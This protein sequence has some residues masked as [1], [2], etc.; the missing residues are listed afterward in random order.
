M[1]SN[2]I[3]S[4]TLATL[5][6]VTLTVSCSENETVITKAVKAESS[7]SKS[8]LISLGVY[9]SPTCGCCKKWIE[10]IEDNGFQSETHSIRDVSIIKKKKGIE[11]RYRSCHTAV[12]NEGYVF[13]GHVP[14]KYIQQFLT[15]KHDDN[16]IGLSVPSMPVGSPG[17]R[18][19]INLVPIECY[20]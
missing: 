3:I 12:S 15:E 19:V 4:K 2:K 9:K 16:V 7:L 14:A 11:P 17:M 8:A 18:L 5:A 6:I 13:E 1:C 20:F 10:H